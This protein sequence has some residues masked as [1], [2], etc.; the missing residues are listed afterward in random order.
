MARLFSLNELL[1]QTNLSLLKVNMSSANTINNTSNTSN[2]VTQHETVLSPQT[3]PDNTRN[4]TS[5]S[6]SST[7]RIF[8]PTQSQRNPPIE[9]QED[10]TVS[11]TSLFTDKTKLS[12]EERKD[13]NRKQEEWA[14]TCTM[15]D[16]K[17][18]DAMANVLQIKGVEINKFVNKMLI[19]FCRAN[20]VKIPAGKGK[21]SFCL[22]QIVAFKKSEPARKKMAEAITKRKNKGT[23]PTIVKSEGTFY[24]AILTILHEQNREIYLRTLGKRTRTCL[25]GPS[26]PYN[27]EWSSLNNFYLDETIKELDIIGPGDNKYWPHQSQVYLTEQRQRSLRR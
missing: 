22:D 25:D 20:G 12:S 9:Y 16:V 3:S 21:R 2:V 15:E 11:A 23:K 18:D 6:S 26:I 7:S 8:T 14:S 19:T 13:R 10:L 1:Q 24:R 17:F 4:N 27:E 5:T